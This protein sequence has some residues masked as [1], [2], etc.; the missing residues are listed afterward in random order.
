MGS[1]ER[2]CNLYKLKKTNSALYNVV[3]QC[4]FQMQW[5]NLQVF[6][7]SVY[8]NCLNRFVFNRFIQEKDSI[9]SDHLLFIRY[10]ISAHN[11]SRVNNLVTAYC[12][13]K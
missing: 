13:N 12:V 4:I 7:D 10:E 6:Q 9:S 11:K 5:S 8:Q 2:V 3:V 1:S